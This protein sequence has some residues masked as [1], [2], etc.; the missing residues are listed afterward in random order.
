MSKKTY[1]IDTMSS[2]SNDSRPNSTTVKRQRLSRSGR[3]RSEAVAA[4]AD[5][6]QRDADAARRHKVLGLMFL[7]HLGAHANT[8]VPKGL[9]RLPT[10]GVSSRRGRKP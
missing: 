10:G 1:S 4:A 7:V 2:R 8:R 6:R 9:G 5:K 3:S